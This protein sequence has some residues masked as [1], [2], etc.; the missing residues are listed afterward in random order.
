M[1]LGATGHRTGQHHR[2]QQPLLS[3]SHQRQEQGVPEGPKHRQ[4]HVIEEEAGKGVGTMEEVATG[5]GQRRRVGTGKSRKGRTEVVA[6]AAE[7]ERRRRRHRQ[8]GRNGVA[9]TGMGPAALSPA[10]MATD[11]SHTGGSPE[12][13]R[14][15][16]APR[17]GNPAC[18]SIDS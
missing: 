8:E 1:N 4:W 18:P 2:L 7:G 12:G 3:S 17:N 10:R 11:A 16:L 5:T 15:G 13:P 9:E 6:A 14:E